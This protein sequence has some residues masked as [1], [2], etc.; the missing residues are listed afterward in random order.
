MTKISDLAAITSLLGSDEFVIARSGTTKRV[1]ASVAAGG[2]IY[3]ST[4]GGDA[5]SIDTGAAGISTSFNHLLILA[6]ARTTQAVVVSTAPITVNNDTA[7]NYD[8]QNI[9]GTAAVASAAEAIAGTNIANPGVPGASAV[10]GSFAAI[11]LVIPAYAQTT[12]HKTGLTFSG[13]GEDTS[14]DMRVSV[15]VGRWRNTAAI[16]RLAIT[17]GS[18]NLLAGS[19]LTVYGI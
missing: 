9:T 3:D 19:R 8:R 18:G 2:L 7:G 13:Y 12:G 17:A 5:A 14:G 6:Y 1:A 15:T 11:L 10:A 16:S 4:L